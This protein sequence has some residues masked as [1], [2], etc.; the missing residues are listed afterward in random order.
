[1]PTISV[2]PL[3][4]TALPNPDAAVASLAVSL[5]NSVHRRK[6][7]AAKGAFTQLLSE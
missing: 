1:M 3:I 4:A 5:A 6:G 2:L 7:V